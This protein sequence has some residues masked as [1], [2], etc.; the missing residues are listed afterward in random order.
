MYLVGAMAF[1]GVRRARPT[2]TLK[3]F[4]LVSRV[5]PIKPSRVIDQT[6]VNLQV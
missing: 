1:Y 4:R 2:R 6:Y 5:G 3:L